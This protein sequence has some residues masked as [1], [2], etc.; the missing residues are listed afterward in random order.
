[1]KHVNCQAIANNPTQIKLKINE[2]K[3]VFIISDLDA[4]LAKFEQALVAVDFDESNDVLFSLGDA[5]DR[6]VCL[7]TGANKDEVLE[8]WRDTGLYWIEDK[9]A[10]CLAGHDVGLEPI[11]MSHLY[12]KDDKSDVVTRVNSW[13]E[14]YDM[15]TA[16]I[17]NHIAD[18]Y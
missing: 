5:I 1:M 6:V 11:I 10:N 18:K 7:D 12:N 2:N 15:V 17:E 4:N 8:E 9:M 3:R 16:D 13:K 14:I